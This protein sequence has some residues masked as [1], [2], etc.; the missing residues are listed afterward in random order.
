[1]QTAPHL[2]QQQPGQKLV[3]TQVRLPAGVQVQGQ[4]VGTGQAVQVRLAAPPVA[5]AAQQ[6]QATTLAAV[7]AQ[8][9]Q[10]PKKG[11]SLTVSSTWIG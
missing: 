2:L 1:M 9:P 5:T 8:T 6:Q 11:L 7:T 4:V 10:Q 3:A